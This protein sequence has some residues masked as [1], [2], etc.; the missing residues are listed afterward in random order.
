MNG[1]HSGLVKVILDEWMPFWS[2]VKAILEKWR[3]SWHGEVQGHIYAI[4]EQNEVILEQNSILERWVHTW[5]Y[6]GHHGTVEVVLKLSRSSWSSGSNPEIMENT[7]EMYEKVRAGLGTSTSIFFYIFSVSPFILY[8]Y[9]VVYKAFHT[10][11]LGDPCNHWDGFTNFKRLW[12]E[13][14]TRIHKNPPNLYMS[15]Q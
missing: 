4:L 7:H 13:N 3:S 6:W 14:Q 15:L 9:F 10:K 8:G 2:I 11:I 1:C 12:L 5:R